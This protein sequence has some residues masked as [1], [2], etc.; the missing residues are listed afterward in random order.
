LGLPTMQKCQ[1]A[2]SNYD[3][4]EIIKTIQKI[5]VANNVLN[6]MKRFQRSKSRR[7]KSCWEMLLS[8][9]TEFTEE[10]CVQVR[11]GESHC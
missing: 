4:W 6:E 7:T 9:G 1:L 5:L 11:V 2:S 10:V 3:F 8:R